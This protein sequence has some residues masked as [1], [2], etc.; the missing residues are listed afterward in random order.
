MIIRPEQGKDIDTIRQIHIQAFG[1]DHESKLVEAVRNSASFIPELSIVAFDRGEIKGHILFSII[2]IENTEEAFISLALAPLAVNPAFQN[3]GIGS[4]LIREGLKVC[5][6]L[7]FASVIVLGH[8]EFYPRFGFVPAAEKD[9]SCPFSVPDE[10]F[11]VCELYRGGLNNVNG[12][13]KYPDY[14]L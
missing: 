2:S 14:F 1:Q 4:I 9:I 8:P 10:A 7:G 12:V 3:K 5:K 11:M 6:K 13:V